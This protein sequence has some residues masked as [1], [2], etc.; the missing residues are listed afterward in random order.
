MKI[1]RP[2]KLAGRAALLV[3]GIALVGVLGS[4]GY[5]VVLAFIPFA[6]VLYPLAWVT[7]FG[8]ARGRNDAMAAR[9]ARRRTV[10]NEVKA[11]A[12]TRRG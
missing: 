10:A 6:L 4:V 1:T 2:I 8:R 11:F 3:A 5:L 7:H 12:R 9:P